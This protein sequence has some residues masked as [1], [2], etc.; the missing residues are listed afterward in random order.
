MRAIMF[1]L[2]TVLASMTC[3]YAQAASP[4]ERFGGHWAGTGTI[5][6]S[7]GTHEPLRCRA[8]YDL[9]DQ[10]NTLE[11]SIRCASDSYNF[12]LLGSAKYDAGAVSGTWTE[13]TRNAAGRISG[14][15]KGDGFQVTA[16]GP[17]FTANLTLT[18]RGDRQAVVIQS[19]EAKTG[20]T[21]A[22]LNL[23]RDN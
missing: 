18:V 7:N 10:N 4:F 16:T 23:K 14:N 2:I 15:A 5:D 19:G 1:T 9:L 11:L 13:A 22:S 21:R 17:T 6:L 12:D 8:S 3:G 20:I